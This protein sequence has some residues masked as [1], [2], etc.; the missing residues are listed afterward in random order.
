MLLGLDLDGALS[1]LFVCMFVVVAFYYSCVTET[2]SQEIEFGIH[3]R[4]TQ[5]SSKGGIQ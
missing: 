1:G 3:N 2:T 5:G 4:I